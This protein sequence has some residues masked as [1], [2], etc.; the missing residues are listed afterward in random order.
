[1]G[2][3]SFRITRKSRPHTDLSLFPEVV[4]DSLCVTLVLPQVP[5]EVLE[6]LDPLQLRPLLKP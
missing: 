2:V 5:H 3:F 1:M 4:L 6:N